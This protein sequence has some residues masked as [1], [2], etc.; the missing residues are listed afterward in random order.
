M[1]DY[2]TLPAREIVPRRVRPEI[3]EDARRHW[4][5]GDPAA[6]HMFNALS[7]GFPRGEKMFVDAVRAHKDR[8]TDPELVDAVRRFVSQET[9]HSVAHEQ[10]NAWLTRQGLPVAEVEAL[11]KRDIDRAEQTLS[12]EVLLAVTAALEHFT[13]LLAQALIEAPDFVDSIDDPIRTMWLWHALE[14]MEHKAVA[15]DVYR[16]VG[17]RES[18]RVASMMVITVLF[19]RDAFVQQALFMRTDGHGRDLASYAKFAKR[20]FGR[21]GYLSG[22]LGRYTAYYRPDFHPWRG[23][24]GSTLRKARA[25]LDQATARASRAPSAT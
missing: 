5:G 7:V 13:A 19:V 8:I 9:Q 4:F 21:R 25:M 23:D 6:T 10:F 12:P 17:G 15:I 1:M 24:D 14:E 3:P 11:V 22:M 2:Q 18:I 20:F 16:H